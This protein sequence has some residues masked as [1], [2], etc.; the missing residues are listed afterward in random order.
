MFSRFVYFAFLSLCLPSVSDALPFKIKAR[1]NGHKLKDTIVE[2]KEISDCFETDYFRIVYRTEEK[3]ICRNANPEL[4]L[5]AATVFYYSNLAFDYFLQLFQRTN[6]N[7]LLEHL[8]SHKFTLRIDQELLYDADTHYGRAKAG[9]SYEIQALTI[10]GGHNEDNTWG[11]ETWYYAGRKRK[12]DWVVHRILDLVNQEHLRSGLRNSLLFQDA[13][14]ISNTLRLPK[15]F[16]FWDLHAESVL[17]SLGLS[18]LLPRGLDAITSLVRQNYFYESALLPEAIVH[19]FSHLALMPRLNAII[20]TAINEGYP[21]YFA[22]KILGLSKLG[23]KTGK[24]SK[25]YIPRNSKSR[26]RLTLQEACGSASPFGSFFYSTLSQIDSALPEARG[27]ELLLHATAS[28]RLSASSTIWD[29]SPA[30]LKTI[31]LGSKEPELE[32]EIVKIILE[33]RNLR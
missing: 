24:V 5:K 18:E 11:P 9:E 26:S 22:G 32:R 23:A 14:S 10:A 29:F 16:Q 21:N 31:E 13:L 30:I 6:S 28:G 7:D 27:E 17:L 20:P 4:L 1:A 3:A 12:K 25:G 33:Q 8:L 19:E 15:A 2:I